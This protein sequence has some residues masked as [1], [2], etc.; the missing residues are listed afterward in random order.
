MLWVVSVLMGLVGWVY[1][2]MGLLVLGV[3]STFFGKE[4]PVRDLWSPIFRFHP[5]PELPAEEAVPPPPPVNDVRTRFLAYMV[6]TLGVFRVMSAFFWQCG[7][8][9]VGVAT[10]LIEIGIISFEVVKNDC[11]V[12]ERAME[13]VIVNVVLVIVYL[14]NFLPSCTP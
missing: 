12:L 9:Y 11:I 6:I 2:M 14:F 3:V 1:V 4:V 5:P 13:P 8:V 7:Y 10:C